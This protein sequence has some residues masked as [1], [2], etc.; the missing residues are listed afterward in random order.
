MA[1]IWKVIFLLLLSFA[2]TP[3]LAA[4]LSIS[5]ASGTF[6]VG[7]RVTVRMVVTSGTPINAIS[8]IVTFPTGL[9]TVESVSK[10]GSILNFWINEPNF[11]Q[12][13]GTLQFEGVTLGGF[14]GGV[15]TV[16][17]ASLRAAKP[18][19]GSIAYK[20]GQILAN[21][22][23]GTDVT[24]GTTGATYSVVPARVQ[25]PAPAPVPVG[26]PLPVEPAQPEPSLK[27]P[28]IIHTRQYGEQAVSGTSEYPRAQ[29]LLTFVSEGGV[30]IF[31][32][33]T[34]DKL[35]QFI[36][37]VPPT[38]K[39]GSY[40]VSAVVIREDFSNSLPSN[41]ITISVGN[42]FSDIGW[43]IRWLII[44]LVLLLVY[45]IVRTRQ[46]LEKNKHLR[47]FV[48][49][50]AEEAEKILHHSFKILREDASSPRK[51]RKDLDE[52]EDLI[53]EE[54]KDIEKS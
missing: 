43:E 30:K 41:E 46:H 19:S 37:L 50:E 17:T 22:G 42:F 18:G 5:P 14:K 21:D 35:G 24:S 52:A 4:T 20:F 32:T 45:L 25:A 38:L 36:L 54:I 33:G 11:S 2:S 27:A 23:Q 48:K 40:T 39:R 9:F 1:K 13:A 29:V 15:E 51:I 44:L 31:I 3:A 12:G 34:T 26:E 10:A 7:E 6:E 28:E 49:K 53:S 16:V 8:G 47:I